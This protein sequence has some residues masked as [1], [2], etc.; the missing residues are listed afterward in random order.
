M[1]LLNKS[2]DIFFIISKLGFNDYFMTLLLSYPTRI[3]NSEYNISLYN[4]DP[5]DNFRVY[6][7]SDHKYYC[8]NNFT[9]NNNSDDAKHNWC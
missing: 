6:N 7:V 9:Y 2:D 5:S 1:N 4:N 3:N 8:A